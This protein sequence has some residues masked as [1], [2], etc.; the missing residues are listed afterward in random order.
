MG[1]LIFIL[2]IVIALALLFLAPLLSAVV[3]AVLV[4]PLL[5]D[6]RH[7][8]WI[9]PI[10]NASV[11]EFFLRDTVETLYFGWAA[12]LA[13]GFI[14]AAAAHLLLPRRL[15]YPT[16]ELDVVA[17][18]IPFVVLCVGV[19]VAPLRLSTAD[20]DR[21]TL[22]LKAELPVQDQQLLDN[23][24][25]LLFARAKCY[26]KC[27]TLKECDTFRLFYNGQTADQLIEEGN[28][29]AAYLR[30]DYSSRI[31][32]LD[33]ALEEVCLENPKYSIGQKNGRP[34]LTFT[35]RNKK[36][37]T[38]RSISG[39]VRV[40]GF[41]DEHPT[42]CVFRCGVPQGL[43]KGRSKE[44][45]VQVPKNGWRRGGLEEDAPEHQAIEVEVVIHRVITAERVRDFREIRKERARCE[46]I[47]ARIDQRRF[48]YGWRHLNADPD[49]YRLHSPNVDFA[50]L[51]DMGLRAE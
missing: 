7:I 42:S 34:R 26:Q 4:F 17:K 24:I 46:N 23:G 38:I 33:W 5:K 30:R 29:A 37:K 47:I 41:G 15:D 18:L 13:I 32:S 10:L 44:C 16:P 50:A 43:A 39:V 48:D 22:K 12:A 20:F 35:L 9:I 6:K 8:Y 19:C 45:V 51:S 11:W 40:T 27:K 1:L 2:C 36:S 14:A 3:A 25:K 49:Y 28:A 21:S 31:Q